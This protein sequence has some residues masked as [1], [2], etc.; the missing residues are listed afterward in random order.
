MLSCSLINMQYALKQEEGGG[1]EYTE[2]EVWDGVGA[3]P[4]L[5]LIIIN[6]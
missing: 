6:I 5:L 2:E 1:K 4:F 3:N